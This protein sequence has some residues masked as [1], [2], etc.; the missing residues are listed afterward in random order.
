MRDTK[1]N[2]VRHPS[3]LSVRASHL[4]VRALRIGAV[5]LAVG[6]VMMTG[7]ARAQEDEDDDKTFEEKIIEGVMAGIGGT[8]MDNR[9][10][11]YRERSPLVVP[12]KLELP[13]PLLIAAQQLQRQRQTLLDLGFLVL[14]PLP[15]FALLLQLRHLQQQSAQLDFVGRAQIRQPRRC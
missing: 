15:A 11:D 9:G 5:A 10:I 14:Q 2:E 6:F 4:S 7:A 13:Q 3:N 12:P 8:N 1:A